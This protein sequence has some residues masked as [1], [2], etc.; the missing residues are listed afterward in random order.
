[1]S[2]CLGNLVTLLYRVQRYLMVDTKLR[3]KLMNR[4]TVTRKNHQS[5]L[6]CEYHEMYQD[7]GI[8]VIIY[9]ISDYN[10]K[11]DFGCK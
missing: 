11:L 2:D 6:S 5:L 8:Q 4:M 10:D 7:H 3:I 9:V 1:M